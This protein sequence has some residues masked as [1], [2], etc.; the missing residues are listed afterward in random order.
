[1]GFINNIDEL[2]LFHRPCNCFMLFESMAQGSNSAIFCC[3]RCK[4][5]AR[6]KI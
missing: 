5:Q 4:E 1:M 2:T 3:P 6:V